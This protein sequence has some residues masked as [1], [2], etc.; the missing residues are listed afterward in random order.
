MRGSSRAFLKE[1][2]VRDTSSGPAIVRGA[3]RRQDP[4]DRIQQI[5]VTVGVDGGPKQWYPWL[6]T[7]SAAP[8]STN[9]EMRK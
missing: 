1:R 8:A 2:N 7:G 5:T 6:E 3:V 9:S 4:G